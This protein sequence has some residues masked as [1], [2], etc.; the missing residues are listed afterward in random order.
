MRRRAF[1]RNSALL[2]SALASPYVWA[3][4]I[5]QQ[6]IAC[7]QYPWHT[8]ME[9]EGRKWHDN[10]DRSM[11]QVSDA[12]FTAFEPLVESKPYLQELLPLIKD[13]FTCHSIYVNSV[14]HDRTQVNQSI[15]EVVEICELAAE[16]GVK[17]VVT[18]PS[19]VKWGGPEDKND[20]QLRVQALSLNLLGSKLK[21]MGMTLAY[22]N[23]DPEMRKSAREFHHMMRATDSENVKLCLDAHWIYRGAGNSRVALEDIVGMYMDRIVELHLR[24]S[25]RY[26]WSEIFTE[27][28]VDYA[29]LAKTLKD[30][31]IQPHLVLE[32]AVE[33]GSPKTM[34]AVEAHR[35]GLENAKSVFKLG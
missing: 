3:S 23:H 13:K 1:V 5:D 20:D 8:F 30:N 21:S 22:H 26:I 32:Q 24:Q 19:P 6:F 33:E 34:S 11:Q 14:L 31:S 4:P 7:Q 29:S 15:A 17:I 2:G 9:R 35:Q 16:I 25:E 27:G 12:G 18:N 10:L 28:D